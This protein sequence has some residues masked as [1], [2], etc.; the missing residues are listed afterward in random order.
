MGNQLTPTERCGD[1]NILVKHTRPKRSF[2][3][4]S[5]AVYHAAAKASTFAIAGAIAFA[6]WPTFAAPLLTIAGAIVATRLVVKIAE[7]Y[8]FKAVEKVLIQLSVFRTKHKYIQVAAVIGIIA[9]TFFCWQLACAL[10]VPVG[11]YAAVVIGLDDYIGLQSYG[12]KQANAR[13]PLAK[14]GKIFIN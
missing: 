6:F 7:R 13:I 9:I 1:V 14:D 4:I 5:P 2:P 10:A 3:R 11:I 12:R 8:H